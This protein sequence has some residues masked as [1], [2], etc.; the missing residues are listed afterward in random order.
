[1]YPPP[2]PR[3]EN[4]FL[5]NKYPWFNILSIR[6]KI[7]TIMLRSMFTWFVYKY[8]PGICGTPE[9]YFVLHIYEWKKKQKGVLIE[10]I[11]PPTR[12]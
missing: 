3:I 5:K 6:H 11:E 1:M 4:H 10:N 9:T 8:G 12:M 2:P 7:N